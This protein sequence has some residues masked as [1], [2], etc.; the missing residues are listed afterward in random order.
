MSLI[1]SPLARPAGRAEGGEQATRYRVVENPPLRMPLHGQGEARGVG[2]PHRLD[3]AVGRDR[4]DRETR[5]QP[6]DRLAVEQLTSMASAPSSSCSSSP[7]GTSST[8]WAG[9]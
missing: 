8:A 4:L 7:P 2:D 5:R 3:R 9:P 1:A 6:V